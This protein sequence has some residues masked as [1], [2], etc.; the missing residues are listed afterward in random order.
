MPDIIFPDFPIVGW[1][2]KES[3]SFTFPWLD[4]HPSRQ[5]PLNL[6]VEILF[7]TN[8]LNLGVATTFKIEQIDG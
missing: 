1:I 4:H 7:V 3:M 2:D 5:I 8:E 6:F